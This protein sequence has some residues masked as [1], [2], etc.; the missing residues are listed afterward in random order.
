MKKLRIPVAIVVLAIVCWFGSPLAAKYAARSMN[1]VTH[2]P[3]YTASPKATSL[4]KKLR[5]VDLHADTLLWGRDLLKR[6][7]SGHIDVPR[8]IAGNVALQAFTVVTKVPRGQNINRTSG[9]SDLIGALAVAEHWPPRTWN[10]LMERALYQAAQLHSAA[11]RSGGKLT[12]V[13]NRRELDAYLQRWKSDS[14]AV[15]GFLGLEGSQALRGDLSKLDD[16][17]RAGFRMIA[18][19]HFFDTEIS[20]S[21]SG[22]SKGG[23]TATGREWVKQVEARHMLIDLAHASPQTIDEVTVI[24]TRPV[25]I[26]HTGVRG[27]CNN[28]RNLPDQQLEEVAKTG[29]VVGVGFWDT[30]TCGTDVASI[31]KTIRYTADKIGV[32]HVALGSDF[33]G[34]VKTPIDATGMAQITEALMKEGFSHED[35]RKIMGENALRVLEQVLPE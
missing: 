29:G 14:E 31:A 21:A 6:S 3:P 27:V 20:G 17:Y 34:S 30:A 10:N 22:V 19:T 7:S 4:H 16:L 35:I 11:E 5:V 23:L 1:G 28:N 8:L 26:S 25:V 18:P 12:I 9:G 2:K 24:A 13:H 32:D 15:G 33:D